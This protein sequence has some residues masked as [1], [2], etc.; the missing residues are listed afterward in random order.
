MGVTLLEFVALFVT[1]MFLSYVV[2]ILLPFLRRAR[3]EPGNSADFDWHFF[4]PA[5]DEE[6]VIETTLACCQRDFPAAHLWVIDDASED[7]TAELVHAVAARDPHVL[8][9]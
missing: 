3:T 5:R 9:I 4:I 8:A 2:M 1:V 7:R 6:A